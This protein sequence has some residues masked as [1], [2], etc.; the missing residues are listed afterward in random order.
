MEYKQ[1]GIPKQLSDRFDTIRRYYGYRSFS[2]FVVDLVRDGISTLETRH[3][4][5]EF[6]EKKRKDEHE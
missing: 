2:E 6:E 5:A 4:L 3:E 1:V